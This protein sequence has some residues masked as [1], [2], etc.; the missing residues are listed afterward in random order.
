MSMEQARIKLS[1]LLVTAYPYLRRYLCAHRCW[2]SYMHRAVVGIRL[3]TFHVCDRKGA[4][5]TVE[6]SRSNCPLLSTSSKKCKDIH[7]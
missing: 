4:H 2:A 5:Q 7:S 3:G 1:T 6:S